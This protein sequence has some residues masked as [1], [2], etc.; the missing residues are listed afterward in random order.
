MPSEPRLPRG[1]SALIVAHP[2]H[3]LRLHGWLEQAR[4]LVF[5]LTDG[6]GSTRESR[7]AGT[8]GVLAAAGA[9]RAPIFGLYSDRQWYDAILRRDSPLFIALSENIAA[10]LVK[11]QVRVVVADAEEGYNSG[12]DLCRAVAD[13][14]VLLAQRASGRDIASFDFLLIGSPETTDGLPAVRLTLDDGAL[15]RKLRAARGYPEMASEV[16]SALS[17]FGAEAFRIECLRS[18]SPDVTPTS[19]RDAPFYE[20]FGEQ[21][22]AAGLYTDVIRAREH[23]APLIEA[24]HHHAHAGTA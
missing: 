5:V 23:I 16:E 24:L 21:Q 12:H 8:E 3:E 13:A 4:P 20:Q 17:R 1:P 14:A 11:E 6:S 22:V 10:T 19:S 18:V 2:G 15:E 7:L 9:R